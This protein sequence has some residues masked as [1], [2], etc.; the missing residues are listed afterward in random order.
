MIGFAPMDLHLEWG[1][2]ILRMRTGCG[3]PFG[4]A[5]IRGVFGACSGFGVGWRT[6]GGCDFCIPG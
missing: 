3:L 5:V 2:S 1:M 6:A 4:A